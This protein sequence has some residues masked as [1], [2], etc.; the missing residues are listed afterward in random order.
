MQELCDYNELP[1]GYFDVV[2]PWCTTAKV[3]EKNVW[4][5]M[6]YSNFV[7]FF[8][9]SAW[10]WFLFSITS[11]LAVEGGLNGFESYASS[12]KNFISPSLVSLTHAIMSTP[13]IA[14]NNSLPA[15]VS[16]NKSILF[17]KM[18]KMY[19]L[20]CARFSSV[21]GTFNLRL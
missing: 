12:S 14:L 20:N 19:R 7:V 10:F 2:L 13:L 17:F 1:L 6:V 5:E 8:L 15:L 21:I 16:H 9:L 11:D 3:N 4:K 18:L